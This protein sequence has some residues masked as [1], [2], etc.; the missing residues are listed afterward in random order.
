MT[1]K[2]YHMLLDTERFTP[3]AI[4]QRAA[5][6]AAMK[7]L[8]LTGLFA[9][10]ATTAQ[11]QYSDLGGNFFSHGGFENPSSGGV[12]PS[13][14]TATVSTSGLYTTSLQDSSSSGIWTSEAGGTVTYNS[15]AISSEASAQ[16]FDN[17][18]TNA[19]SYASLI[20]GK[21]L[22]S[23]DAAVPFTLNFTLTADTAVSFADGSDLNELGSSFAIS[24]FIPTKDAGGNITNP[25]GQFVGSVS[26]AS[27]AFRLTD[28]ETD[29]FSILLDPD[30][31][32]YFSYSTSID[33][34]L[35]AN[36]DDAAAG[37]AAAFASGGISIDS[38]TVGGEPAD[39]NI[40]SESGTDYNVP[41]PGVYAAILG[42]GVLGFAIWRRRK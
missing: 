12:R 20:N 23:F 10:G 33:T 25:T 4:L 11:A 28:S 41:E 14:D 27:N 18:N 35:T 30:D 22:L 19:T 15:A 17:T 6:T 2:K 37:T 21:D 34:S 16:A 3:P 29:S 8:T 9:L 13:P 42:I 5:Q 39:I 26:V 36:T 40:T 38:L 24:A 31:S 32:L 7:Q 1:T